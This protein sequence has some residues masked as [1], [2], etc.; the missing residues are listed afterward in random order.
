M[1]PAPVVRLPI[2]ERPLPL[3]S[4]VKTLWTSEMIVNL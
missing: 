2:H 4:N 3:S 1:E